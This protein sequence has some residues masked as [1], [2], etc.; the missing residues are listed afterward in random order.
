M[1]TQLQDNIPW[2]NEDNSTEP[3][4]QRM[5]DKHC[6]S[7]PTGCFQCYINE[8]ELMCCFIGF[9]VHSAFDL[10]LNTGRWRWRIGVLLPHLQPSESGLQ[11]FQRLWSSIPLRLRAEQLKSGL[12]KSLLQKTNLKRANDRVKIKASGS[13]LWRRI[14]C[15]WRFLRVKPFKAD[16]SQQELH[17][18]D[19]GTKKGLWVQHQR[20]LHFCRA[21]EHLR[22][23]D[24]VIEHFPVW[25]SLGTTSFSAKKTIFKK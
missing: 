20:L 4:N 24:T 7:R 3:K 11:I 1:M 17:G 8:S 5:K 18:S 21:E 15:S 13:L 19:C 25:K 23:W 6:L 22:R 10:N 12:G 9:A 16:G 14:I 2:R